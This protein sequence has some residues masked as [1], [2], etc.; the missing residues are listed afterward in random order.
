[1]E[2]S[3]EQ[4]KKDLIQNYNSENIINNNYKKI[5]TFNLNLNKKSKL[6]M[7]PTKKRKINIKSSKNIDK[8]LKLKI[9]KEI[10]LDKERCHMLNQ[11]MIKKVKDNAYLKYDK[12]FNKKRHF[13]IM[14]DGGKPV[15]SRY[16]DAIEI[17]SIFATIS[18]MITK[19]TIFNSNKKFNEEINNI[20]N[21]K[22]NIVF[23]KKGQ[24]IFIALSK[25]I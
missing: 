18:A 16:G 8:H 5:E 20:S 11:K 7:T 6:E 3:F 15:Y 24:L 1:M 13:L 12:F 19:F 2:E 10:L 25:K 4:Q 17:N 21:N 22:N 14:T 9:P 23:L